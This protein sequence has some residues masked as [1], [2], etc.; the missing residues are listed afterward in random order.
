VRTWA[1]ALSYHSDVRI[2]ALPDVPH[3]ITLVR[4]DF[5]K[6]IQSHPGLADRG[7][8]YLILS[9]RELLLYRIDSELER[10]TEPERLFDGMHPPSDEAIELILQATQTS[11]PTA[12]LRNLPVELQD[13]IL[14]RVSAGPIESARVGCPLDAGSIFAWSCGNRKIEREEGRRS[15]TPW[16]PVESHICFRGYPSGIAYK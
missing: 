9:V 4:E 14:N 7:L 15:R 13:A 6:Q 1:L 16:T 10:Y 3:A 2:R 8:T 5:A 12:P 11:A